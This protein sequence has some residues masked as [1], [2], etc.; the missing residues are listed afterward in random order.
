MAGE[1][2]AGRQH[3]AHP[4]S[5]PGGEAEMLRG[6]ESRHEQVLLLRLRGKQTPEIQYDN[7][8]IIHYMGG[9]GGGRVPATE[10]KREEEKQKDFICPLSRCLHRNLG[11][12]GYIESTQKYTFPCYG[13]FSI[14]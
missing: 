5:G 2:G 7:S 1:D 10:E 9:G 3:W 4:L 13:I 6:E 14:I 12:N 8:Q 11:R